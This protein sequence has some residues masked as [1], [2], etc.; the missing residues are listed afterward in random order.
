[1]DDLAEPPIVDDIEHRR[2]VAEAEAKLFGTPAREVCIGRFAVRRRLGVGGLGVVYAAH[3]PELDR[4]VAIKLLRT[5]DGERLRREARAMAKL[6]H[7]N[8]VP[9]YEVGAHDGRVFIAMELV[10]GRTLRRWV[11]DARPDWRRIVAAYV[12]AGR[13]LVAAH[14]AG[15]VHRDFKP[16]NVMIGGDG[17][18]R[19][20]DFGLAHE[21]S[22]SAGTPAYMAPEQHAGRELTPAADQ[23]AFCVALY[24]ALWG[25]RPFTGDDLYAAKTVG[26]IAEPPAESPV[27]RRIWLAIRRGLASRPG[28]RWPSLDALL[29]VIAAAPRRRVLRWVVIGVVVVIL[30]TALVGALLQMW[31]FE[32]WMNRSHRG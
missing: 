24:E 17:R 29:A 7:A 32:D 23:F 6:A 22:A 14:A 10:D 20:T 19:V 8:V 18:A 16:D 12:D 21:A 27:P 13:G 5:G 26:G 4:E 31:M 9:V 1:V 2:V 25:A 28:D 30:V 3:D 11:A 15:I